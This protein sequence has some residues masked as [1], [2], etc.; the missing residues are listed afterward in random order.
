M[1]RTY[2]L[3]EEEADFG[4][5]ANLRKFGRR[6][7]PTLHAAA[8]QFRCARDCA[9]RRDGCTSF[10]LA[11]RTLPRAHTCAER[12]APFSSRFTSAFF[13][14]CFRRRFCGNRTSLTFRSLHVVDPKSRKCR[15]NEAIFLVRKEGWRA[16]GAHLP[17][18]HDSSRVSNS[19]QD[20][21]HPRKL[22]ACTLRQETSLPLV[23]SFPSLAP[24]GAAWQTTST[25]NAA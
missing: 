1:P 22:P 4:D 8:Q 17:L 2:R 5:Q 14:T 19:S 15:E 24:H 16:S 18:Q 13:Q 10:M 21:V 9:R 25:N 23:L 12:C 20:H 6:R 3:R 11:H 7:P